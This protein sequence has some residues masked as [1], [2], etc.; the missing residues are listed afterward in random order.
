MKERIGLR[1]HWTIE[2]RKNG[3]LVKVID[4]DN[5]LTNLYKNDVLTQLNSGTTDDLQIKYLGIGTGTNP[6]S[7]T[8]TQLQAE[9]FRVQ[10]TS[11]AITA[12]YAQTIWVIPVQMG[13]FTYREIGVFA[14]DATATLNSGMLISRVN[15]NIEKTESMEVTFVRRDYVTI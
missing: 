12:D 7:P 11:R 13:N 8:D 5:Q 10:P 2:I 15:V 14:G 6:A 4:F 9:V 3:K 1:G